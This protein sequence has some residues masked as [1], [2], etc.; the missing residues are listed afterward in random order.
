VESILTIKQFPNVDL[1]RGKM[2]ISWDDRDISKGKKS[3]EKKT[4]PR[5]WRKPPEQCVN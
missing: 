1:A 2:V 4:I 3:E 5:P